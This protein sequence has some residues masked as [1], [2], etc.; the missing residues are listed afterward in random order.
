MSNYRRYRPCLCLH[1]DC[2]INA[3][4]T[5]RRTSVKSYRW[6]FSMIFQLSAVFSLILFNIWI[7]LILRLCRAGVYILP[8]FP[9]PPG[10]GEFFQDSRKNPSPRQFFVLYDNKIWGSFSRGRGGIF[11]RFPKK[12]FPKAIFFFFTY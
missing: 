8:L 5:F 3:A 2:K 6:Q 10:G 4:V 11:S 12:P 9:P 1:F 7:K